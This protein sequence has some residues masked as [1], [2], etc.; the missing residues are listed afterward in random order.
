MS[1]AARSVS[2]RPNLLQKARLLIIEDE[3]AACFGMP[4]ALAQAGAS[5]HVV[6]HVH[7]AVAEASVQK[8]DLILLGSV[9]PDVD[10]PAAVR[11]L[12]GD[13]RTRALPLL[14]VT[15]DSAASAAEALAAGADDCLAE[16]VHPAILCARAGNLVARH[17]A[18]LEKQHLAHNLSRYISEPARTQHS[19]AKTIEQIEAAVLFSDLRGFTATSFLED[20]KRI[21]TAVSDVLARQCDLVFAGGGYVDKFSGDGILAIFEGEQGP[22]CACRVALEILRWAR[23]FE[24]IAFWQPPPI[25]LGIHWGKMLRGDLGSERRR[26]HTVLGSTVNIAARLCGAALVLEAIASESVVQRVYESFPFLPRR[27]VHLR[28]LPDE[29]WVYPLRAAAAPRP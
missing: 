12:R 11:A 6:R 22:T 2:R 26:E 21:F 4:A 18:E 29:A 8:P 19:R 15:N 28:G 24:A 1:T 7:E 5:V 13:P 16:P 17:R 20:P 27:R 25:G 10:V 9:T 3:H 23:E 14:A